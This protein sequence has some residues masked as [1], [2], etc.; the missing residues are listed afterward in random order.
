MLAAWV[1]RRICPFR[2]DVADIGKLAFG[3]SVQETFAGHNFHH[4]ITWNGEVICADCT[5]FEGRKQSFVGV[6]CVH[7]YL[8]AGFG[9]E[10]FQQFGRHIFEPV[11]QHEFALS[12]RSIRQ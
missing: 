8:D 10:F 9:C 7:R 6:V 12:G 1:K 5:G 11:I 2:C 3:D 4:I